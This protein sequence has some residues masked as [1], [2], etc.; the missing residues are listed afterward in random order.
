MWKRLSL[1]LRLTILY[2]GLLTLLLVILCATFFVDTRNLLVEITASHIR[3]TAKPVIEHWL[4]GKKLAGS[5]VKG[6]SSKVSANHLKQIAGFLARDLT[7]RNTVALVLDKKGAILASGRVLKEEPIPP[8]P[9]PFYYRQ[10]LSGKNEVTYILSKDGKNI[11]VILIPLRGAPGSANI[12]GVAQLS[13]PLTRIEAILYRHGITLIAGTLM[14]LLLGTAL[15]LLAISSALGD[16]RQMITTCQNITEGKLDQRVNLPERSDEVG[17]LAEA[18]NKMVERLEDAFSAQKRFVASAA[19]E[20]RT[21]LTAL[22]GSVE[23]LM[24][25]AQDDPGAVASL[26]Q[27]MHRE[28]MRLTGLCEKLLDLARLEISA[29]VRKEKIV[30]SEFLRDFLEQGKVLASNRILRVE[31][32]PFLCV[33]ADPHLLKQIMFDLVQNAVRYTDKG[34]C[35]TLGWK[36]RENAAE[37]WV[38]DNGYGILAEDISR[39]FEPFYRGKNVPGTGKPV[40]GSGLGLALVKAMVEAH[41]GTITVESEPNRGSTFSIT[42]PF[43]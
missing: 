16:L 20:L 17:Q 19:H 38:K 23:V 39:I 37:L 8:S 40:Q 26:C 28:I 41:G 1:R 9:V 10:A 30:I 4:Y 18:F 42:L 22:R 27:G 35:I 15:G 43:K 14:T 3:A 29:N 33:E 31:E 25:G 36:L 6:K 13:S 32:G 7:S 5:G 34:G 11:L 2:S 21:P 24:R 12:V